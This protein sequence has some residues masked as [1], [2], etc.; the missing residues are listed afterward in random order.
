MDIQLLTLTIGYSLSIAFSLGFA[1]FVLLKNPKSQGNILFFLFTLL[2]CAFEAPY[3]IGINL[4][5]PQASRLAFMFIMTTPFIVL[6]NTHL[7]F[8]ITKAETW[9]KRILWVL[10]GVTMALNIYYLINPETFLLLSEP[11]LY[12]PNHLVPG[13]LYFVRDALFYISLVFLLINMVVSFKK[14]DPVLRNRLKYFILAS[15]LAYTIGLIPS[16]VLYGIPINPFW[17]FIIGIYNIPMVYAIIR[18]ELVDIRIVAK[19]A[20]WYA[21]VT[22]SIAF[23]F[24]I[25]NSLNETLNSYMPSLPIWIIPLVSAGVAVII[26]V[27]VWNKIK[28]AEILKYEFINVVTHKFRTPLTYIKWSLETLQTSKNEQ[29]RVEAMSSI[30]T[31]NTRLVE[32]T[33]L[34]VETASTENDKYRYTLAPQNIA[35][36]LSEIKNS[37]APKIQKKNLNVTWDIEPSLHSITADHT[38]LQFALQTVIDNAVTYTPA[39]GHIEIR[40][41]QKGKYL[42]ITVE[43][44]GIG[45]PKEELQF[46]FSKFFRGVQATLTDTEGMGIGLY[47]A[48]EIV[49][50]HGG[51]IALISAGKDKGTTV[52]VKVPYR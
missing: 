52:V 1:F 19:R 17:S 34:L 23:F 11:A 13:S 32:L 25:I 18:Y 31:A 36:I 6:V 24:F 49:E 22:G 5:D 27:F 9:K 8:W 16:F 15:V 29:E 20:L 40:A 50:R 47:L 21:L 26:G 35:E 14:A 46:I 37:V 42:T 45:I 10:Y 38:K 2:C 39:G 12:L 33:N 41:D 48:K 4:A 30:S 7:L 44:S 51:Q 3:I 28:E 43:D